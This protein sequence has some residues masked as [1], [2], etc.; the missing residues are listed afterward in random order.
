MLGGRITRLFDLG[1]F[2]LEDMEC[3][4]VRGV[5]ILLLGGDDDFNFVFVFSRSLD[6]TQVSLDFV[7]TLCTP[8]YVV[9]ICELRDEVGY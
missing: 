7:V 4:L 2:L 9:Y 8:G 6:S 3:I 5:D 1:R